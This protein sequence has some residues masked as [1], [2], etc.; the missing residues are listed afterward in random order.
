MPINLKVK[1]LD[2]RAQLPRHAL[3]GDA[4]LDLFCLEEATIPP[5]ARHIFSTG[6]AMEIPEG[7]VGLIWDRSGH[8]NKRGLK[9]F[10]GVIDSGY[11]GEVMVCLYNSTSEPVMLAAAS[12]VAQILIQRIE[13]VHVI[14]SNE[15]RE[16]ARGIR[17]FGSTGM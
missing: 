16:G 10:G 13:E 8:S 7:Y 6:I 14:E 4:G 9:V 1:R 3:Q 5:G 11:R 17:G 12:A 2:P 15:L